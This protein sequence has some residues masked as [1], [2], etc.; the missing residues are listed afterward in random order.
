MKKHLKNFV[1]LFVVFGGTVSCSPSKIS[2]VSYLSQQQ[3]L[4]GGFEIKNQKSVYWAQDFPIRYQVSSNFPETHYVA[5]S[6]AVEIWNTTFNTTIFELNLEDTVNMQSP[7]GDGR[8]IIYWTENWTY[9]KQKHATTF[10][11][12][13][14]N[15]LVEAD[16]AVNIDEFNMGLPGTVTSEYD[17][18]S[19]LVHEL[20]HV[21]GLKHEDVVAGSVMQT[22][23][24][25]GE[26]RQTLSKTDIANIQCMYL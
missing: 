19:I 10:M 3:M 17:L 24:L 8:N 26:V 18:T 23:I 22:Y 21:L 5:V 16:I 14:A 1:L 15:N 9:E 4:C 20:G 25:P 13:H 11:Y 6:K 7:K 12:L 2:K